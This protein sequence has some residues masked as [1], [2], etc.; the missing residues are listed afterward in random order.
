MTTPPV[1]RGVK[2][3][4]HNWA[5]IRV[6]R[7]CGTAVVT[8]G[9]AACRG[10]ATQL[11]AD[12][13]ESPVTDSVV[14][15]QLTSIGRDSVLL[16]WYRPRATGGYTFHFAQWTSG[17]WGAPGTVVSDDSVFMHPTDLP[18][19]TRL[20]NGELAAVWQRRVNKTTSGDGW[21][22]EFR[23]QFSRDAGATWSASVIP[24]TGSTRGGEH[25]FHTAWATTDGKLGMAWID[26]RDQT[27]VT[28]KDTTVPAQYLGAMQ[29][30]AT[31]VA[32]DGSVAPE[33]IVDDVMCECCPNAAVMTPDGPI[34]AYRDKRVP[35]GVPR[36]SLRY[37]MNVLRDLSLARLVAGDSTNPPHWV[38]GERVTNDGWIYNGCPNNGP[39]LASHDQHVA[40]AW[41]TGE[42]ERPRVQI[43]WSDDGGRSFGPPQIVSEGRA[44]G[45]VSVAVAGPATV[46]AWLQAGK[47][48][49][50]R[51]DASGV[52]GSVLT[53]GPSGGKHR[54]PS[55]VPLSDGSVLMGW[56]APGGRLELRRLVL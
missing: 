36:D 43:R 24:H 1:V 3:P 49:A 54:L 47:V 51:F 22:Y 42:G 13:I 4:L 19:I 6:V 46:V 53:V 11:R 34:V 38:A 14:V 10:E 33:A 28:P 55:M 44:D 8:F 35:D 17:K 26:P 52:P 18:S 30:V 56:I 20:A 37:E 39:A 29:L 25:E 16:A 12:A 32:P 40:L 2:T 7:L 23:V 50:R 48:L 45:Q 31:S 41:W 9:L 15:P 5:R 21:Q 27:V